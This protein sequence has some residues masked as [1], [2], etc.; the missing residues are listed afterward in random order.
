MR[1]K[2]ASKNVPKRRQWVASAILAC[3]GITCSGELIHAQ[4]PSDKG[5][6][7]V[8]GAD[9]AFINDAGPGGEAEVQLGRLAAERAASTKVRQFA[10]QMVEDHSKAGA[11]LKALAKEK[12]VALPPEVMPKARQMKEKLSKLRGAEFDREYVK[13]MVEMHEK[14]VAAFEAFAK[15]ATDADVKTF[16]AATLP[17]LKHHLEMIRTL[18]QSMSAPAK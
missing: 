18:E 6:H 17:T 12:Q 10:L 11:K 7:I 3:M 5:D 13:V 16:A 15:S 2:N 9:L 1:T 14:D 8:T 4:P